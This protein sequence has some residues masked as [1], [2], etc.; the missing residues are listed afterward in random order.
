[1]ISCLKD[2]SA[3]NI[4]VIFRRVSVSDQYNETFIQLPCVFPEIGTVAVD[5]IVTE[6]FMGNKQN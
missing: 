4:F 1:M 6:S 3:A 2:G 5:T